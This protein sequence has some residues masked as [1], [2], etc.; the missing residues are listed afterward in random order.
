MKASPIGP[1]WNT[2]KTRAS[3]RNAVNPYIQYNGRYGIYSG[4]YRG[5][6][7]KENP[8]NESYQLSAAGSIVY[9]GES[10]EFSR[11]VS[12]SFA[13]IKVGEVPGV[14]AYHNNK[15]IGRTDAKG[16]TVIPNL[17]SYVDN[18]LSINDQDIPVDYNLSSVN[19]YISPPLRSGS[20]LRF[21]ATKTQALSGILRVKR[22]T[23][24]K[25][26]EN[27]E[28]LLKIGDQEVPYLTA[29]DGEF[30][31]ENIP[32]GVYEASVV[33]EG[34]RLFFSLTVPETDDMIIELGV[35]TIEDRP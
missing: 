32:P 18:Y 17:G 31:L 33:Y 14:R 2:G 30:Y 26:V 27:N 25:P 35:V 9:V 10:I 13:V 28:I 11:P 8:A 21:E 5:S 22:G 19:R 4:E 29:R 34:K 24:V 6:Y 23:E 12:D 1:P 16:R 7:E 15:E 3:R 20:M